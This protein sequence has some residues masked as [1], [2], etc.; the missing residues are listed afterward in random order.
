MKMLSKAEETRRFIDQ[1]MAKSAENE[2]I[3]NEQRQIREAMA[4]R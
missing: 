4:L 1:M 2:R 3:R